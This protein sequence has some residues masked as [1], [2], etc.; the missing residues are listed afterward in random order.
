MMN[1]AEFLG[2]LFAAAVA[3]ACNDSDG[4]G[5]PADARDPDAR[6]IDAK[7]IDA[8]PIDAAP[9]ACN[10]TSNTISGNHGHSL[11][12]P[13]ADVN[14]G[15]DKSY[16]IQ[17]AAGHPHTIMVTAAQ[18]AMLK[19]TFSISVVSSEDNFHMHTVT[20]TCA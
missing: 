4:Q 15:A 10:T 12:V 8:R 14:A 16:D 18:F 9:M 13:I 5:P 20:I 17:G 6:P 19:T 1:R 2:S 3:S 7:P 11:T